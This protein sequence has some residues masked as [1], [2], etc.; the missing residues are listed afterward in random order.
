MAE[1]NGMKVRAAGVFKD[2]DDFPD[3]PIASLKEDQPLYWSAAEGGRL[4]ALVTVRFKGV[5]NSYCRLV[6]L[7][8]EKATPVLIDAPQDVNSDAC[9]GFRDVYYLD[10]NEDGEL[11]IVAIM[12]VKA[13]SFDGYVDQP[14]VYLSNADRK[15]GYCYSASASRNMKPAQMVSTK[16]V[17][18]ALILER[19][20][21]GIPQ[22]ECVAG[23][24][25]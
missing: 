10:V 16:K 12:N 7:E 13:N 25:R 1:F 6:T 21:L 23:G 8:N 19:K 17:S 24:T 2:R 11:D 20:R 18:Q 5:S 14:V 4:L 3:G 15:G 22:F 9:R